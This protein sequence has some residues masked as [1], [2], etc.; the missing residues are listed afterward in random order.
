MNDTKKIDLIH[1]AMPATQKYVYLNTGTAGPL[2]TMTFEAL[3]Q[4]NKFNFDEGRS[5]IQGFIEFMKN[6]KKLRAAFANVINA[7]ADEIALT[8]HTT[9]GMNIIVHGLDWQKNDELITTNMEHEGGLMPLYVLRQRHG[10]II[11]TTDIT[12]TAT[13]DEIVA[14][15]ENNITPRTRL[16]AISHVAW[17]TGICLPVKEIVEMARRH[18][19]LCLIDAAQSVGAIPI[20]MGKLGADF[21]AMP[22]QKWLCGPEGIGALYVRKESLSFISPTFMG[23]FSLEKFSSHDPTGY[24]LP[25][26][27]TRRFE[28]GTIHRPGIKAMVANLEWLSE[29]IGWDWIYARI[30]HLA[31]YAHQ[32]LRQLPNVNMITPQNA[33]S[34]LVTFQLEGYKPDRVMVKLLQDN[35]VLRFVGH[36]HALRISTGFYNTEADIDKLV[37]ALQKILK[38]DSESL[39]YFKM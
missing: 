25:A 4:G 32:A 29:T 31:N 1:S 12:P 27:T 7:S 17:N 26:R 5:N 16:I 22:G 23:L 24:F 9:E 13:T 20:D 28:V 34:G 38:M 37:I 33:Q 6:L 19:V 14:Q 2:S 3:N 39:P 30:A 35:I 18:H 36:P 10:V 15:I 11:R 21:Y 8:H